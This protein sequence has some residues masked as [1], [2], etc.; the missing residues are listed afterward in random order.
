M[1]SPKTQLIFKEKKI[2]TNQD[3]EHFYKQGIKE[4]GFT[5][6]TL[7]YDSEEQHMKK[8]SQAALL[9]RDCIQP[10]DSIVDIGCGW[11]SLVPLLPVCKYTG[12]DLISEFIAQA[13]VRFPRLDFL[14]ADFKDINT[15]FDWCLLVGIVSCIPNPERLIEL[16]WS[17][18]RKGI[19][20]DF[21]CEGKIV[22]ELNTFN[23]GQCLLKFLSLGAERVEVFSTNDIWTFFIV[24]KA[25]KWLNA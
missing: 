8:I 12:V 19:F 14:H 25:G 11:G 4:S 21:T 23:L 22:G 1:I 7:G 3:L 24:Q 15:S 17:K 16:A 20:V 13:K 5:G 2:K 10:D 9:L 6:V 18:A